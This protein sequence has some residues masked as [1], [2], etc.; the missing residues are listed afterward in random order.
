[1]RHD[2]GQ[3]G[4]IVLEEQRCIVTAYC[5]ALGGGPVEAAICESRWHESRVRRGIVMTRRGLGS[6]S[7]SLFTA[8]P[9]WAFLLGIEFLP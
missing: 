7:L 8:Y 5:V 9:L 4:F 6:T 2:E 1:M 3:V